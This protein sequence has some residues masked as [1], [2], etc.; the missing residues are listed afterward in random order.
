VKQVKN[1]PHLAFASKR[2]WWCRGFPKRLVREGGY[3]LVRSEMAPSIGQ[4][5]WSISCFEWGRNWG[6]CKMGI[7]KVVNGDA[8]IKLTI[9]GATMGLLCSK[10]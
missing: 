5:Y 8:K 2:G 10:A 9:E 1:H 3:L 7:N 6:G 4:W